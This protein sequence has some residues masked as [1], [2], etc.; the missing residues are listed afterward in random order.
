MAYFTF[1]GN[2]AQNQ[3]PRQLKSSLETS[4]GIALRIQAQNAQMTEA[5]MQAQWGVPVGLTEA[6]W[7]TLINNLVTSLQSASVTALT[8][9]MGF[10]T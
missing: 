4:L 5:D 9:Q 10:S 7:E 2:A 1:N 6:Q 8:T 3:L